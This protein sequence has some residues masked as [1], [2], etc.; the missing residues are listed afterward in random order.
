MGRIEEH[1]AVPEGK[2]LLYKD[3]VAGEGLVS[4]M[5]S[6]EL[7]RLGCR[8]VGDLE[9]MCPPGSEKRVVEI[10]EAVWGFGGWY[11]AEVGGVR[12]K[13]DVFL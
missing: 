10:V 8:E 9:W 6:E 2:E 4:R 12:V 11:Q 5:V 13:L 1:Y 7:A 3:V